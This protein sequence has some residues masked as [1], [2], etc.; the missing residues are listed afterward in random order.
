MPNNND[1]KLITDADAYYHKNSTYEDDDTKEALELYLK[2]SNKNYRVCARIA[3]IYFNKAQYD[4][5]LVYIKNFFKAEENDSN[6]FQI[7][8]K[9]LINFAEEIGRLA[10][11]LYIK[12]ET[13]AEKAEAPPGQPHE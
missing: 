10:H 4:E 1:A 8:K 12:H 7:Y 5:A 2:V 11:K 13:F 3:T 9:R 6:E